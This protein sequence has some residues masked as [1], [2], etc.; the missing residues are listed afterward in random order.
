MLT[1]KDLRNKG[2]RA[3]QTEA[4][5][6]HPLISQIALGHVPEGVIYPGIVSNDKPFNDP[7]KAYYAELQTKYNELKDAA[8]RQVGNYEFQAKIKE[9]EELNAELT[10]K[11]KEL[12]EQLEVSKV[13]KV[14]PVEFQQ[15]SKPGPKPKVQ[16]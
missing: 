8:S 2:F 12:V 6:L 11:N 7:L 5:E 4:Q 3:T 9:L 13:V 14:E 16:V 1:I 15:R 10:E